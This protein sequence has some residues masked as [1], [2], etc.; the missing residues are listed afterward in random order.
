MRPRSDKTEILYLRSTLRNVGR[1]L[2]GV[3]AITEKGQ[4]HVN[5][6]R[7]VI[8]ERLAPKRPPAP[9]VRRRGRE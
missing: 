7:H 4:S 1:L 5:Y 9:R 2:D 6:C 8:A 3:V